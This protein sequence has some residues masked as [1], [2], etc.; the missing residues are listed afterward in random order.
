MSD[1]RSGRRRFLRSTAAAAIGITGG[2]AASGTAGAAPD[3]SNTDEIR[4]YSSG[5]YWEYQIH[6]E[7]GRDDLEKGNRANGHDKIRGWGDYADG[8]I[9]DGGVDN[10]WMDSD[11][12]ITQIN[13]TYD[14]YGWLQ[15][16]ID[17]TSAGYAALGIRRDGNP[18]YPGY[19]YTIDI[20]GQIQPHHD[21]FDH[22][23]DEI[24]NGDVGPFVG[25]VDPD[26]IDG[27]IRTGPPTHVFI[28][29]PD[30]PGTGLTMDLPL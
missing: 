1:N 13:V 21:Y 18:D 22:G 26:D 29:D 30:S 24:R 3:T 16:D 7:V 11:D 9:Y 28:E 15:I 4:V 27:V 6:T 14:D 5:N 25:T 20:D 17:S 10:Y 19:D 23:Q 8:K 2:I 12:W